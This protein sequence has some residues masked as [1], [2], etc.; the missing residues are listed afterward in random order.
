[1]LLLALSLACSPPTS[2][3]A[4]EAGAAQPAPAPT[5]RAI[6]VATLRSDLDAGRVPVLIDVRTPEEFAEGH[7]A[8][9]RNIPVSEIQGRIG[10][11]EAWRGKPVYLI[12][13]SGGRSAAAARI[14]TEKGFDTVDVKGGT[15]AWVEAGNPSSR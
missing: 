1:M 15:Q 7:V 10:E 13:R 11:L 14:L 2:P 3:P 4:L 5:S 8:G 6:D 12:C 9:A